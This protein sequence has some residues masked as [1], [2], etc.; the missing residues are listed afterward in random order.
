MITWTIRSLFRNDLLAGICLLLFSYVPLVFPSLNISGKIGSLVI[1]ASFYLG[2]LLIGNHITVK[3]GGFS[4][5]SRIRGSSRNNR[6]FTEVIWGGAI[7]F[8]LIAADLGGLWYFPYWSATDYVFIGFILGGWV[9]YVITLIV[10]YEAIKLIL[11]RLLPR[12]P[13]VTAY[14][15]YERHL[16]N[17]LLPL[18]VA[19]LAVVM[20][21][22]MKN[23]HFFTQFHYSVN[24]AKQPYLQWYYWL[25]AFVGALFICE[26]VEFR[27]KRSSLLKDT[28][29]G[30]FNPLLAA[31]LAGTVLAIANEVQNFGVYLWRYA[32]Y[33]WPNT[34]LFHI[35]IFIILAWPLHIIAF[36][37][38]WRA[39]GNGSSSVVFANAK[40]IRTRRKSKFRKFALA[41]GG[42]RR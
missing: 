33:P 5:I 7:F 22:A 16:Y 11:D 26:Y 40:K 25:L 37:M 1:G 13:R 35:P 42:A 38:F 27:R 6:N 23:T 20:G 10:C 2:A 14:F 19:A 15:K 30:Y 18:G 3:L 4:L 36:V 32:N 31:I 17:L 34:T 21:V 39:F 24:V 12:Q 8:S 29:H 28:L 9:F 41:A